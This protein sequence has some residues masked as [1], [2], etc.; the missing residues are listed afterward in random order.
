MSNNVA[1]LIAYTFFFSFVSSFLYLGVRG[2]ICNVRY[3]KWVFSVWLFDCQMCC[4]LFFLYKFQNQ[5]S[6]AEKKKKQKKNNTNNGSFH[7]IR[8]GC[9]LNLLWML[10]TYFFFSS[11]SFFPFFFISILV[12]DTK[13]ITFCKDHDSIL[14]RRA[15]KGKQKKNRRKERKKESLENHNWQLTLGMMHIT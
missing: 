12:L 3:Y 4:N 1:L 2:Y 9:H 13:A 5:I 14:N 15:L 10:F 8:F 7:F 6:E 11:V